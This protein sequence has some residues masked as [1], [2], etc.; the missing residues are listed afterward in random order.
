MGF[1]RVVF[2]SEVVGLETDEVV[3]SF[4]IAVGF[5]TLLTG[6]FDAVTGAFLTGVDVV[7]GL[8]LATGSVFCVPSGVLALT[9]VAFAGA[10]V[11]E[12]APAALSFLGTFLTGA[13]VVSVA[14]ALDASGFLTGVAFVAVDVTAF[15]GVAVDF[16]AV[17]PAP[18]ATFDRLP[19]LATK[20]S[21]RPCY[22]AINSLHCSAAFCCLSW[23]T[24]DILVLYG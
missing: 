8:L 13:V 12:D 4:L 22:S 2:N 24:A 5:D 16:F 15:V 14:V 17:C 23:S 9:G 6:V 11:D 10:G 7:S 3:V 1:G 19:T 20:R 21:V 18:C